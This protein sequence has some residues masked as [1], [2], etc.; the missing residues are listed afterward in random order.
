MRNRWRPL[1]I[2]AITVHIDGKSS[3]VIAVPLC[4]QELFEN[5]FQTEYVIG[6]RGKENEERT[7]EQLIG[8]ANA[9]KTRRHYARHG[10]M[11]EAIK[12]LYV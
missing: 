5:K 7:D 9:N 4:T 3:C 10:G 1:A 12:Y 2:D 11:R 8:Q 6:A